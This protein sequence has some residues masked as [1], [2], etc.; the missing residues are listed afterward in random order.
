MNDTL[1]SHGW[2]DFFQ[3]ELTALGDG[4]L[5]PGRVVAT[6]RGRL[7]LW[8]AE[9]AREAQV[10]GRRLHLAAGGAD[11]P[12]VGDW[13]VFDPSAG[14]EPVVVRELLPRRTSL[15]RKAAGER[16]EEQVVAANVDLVTVVMG[17]D[18]DYSPRRLERYLAMIDESGAAAAVVLN[19]ADVCT[20]VAARA[21]TR[22]GKP[23]AKGLLA[24][25][26][27]PVITL[28]MELSFRSSTCPPTT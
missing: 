7:R 10:A 13:V 11:L 5:R 1:R 17:L 6:Q 12:V 22:R 21:V 14:K 23:G 9:G 8:T 2:S 26:L 18:G 19:K 24:S 3:Q 4:S 27:P 16:T 28:T 25:G 15:S 20:D